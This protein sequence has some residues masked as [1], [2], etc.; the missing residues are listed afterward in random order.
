[1][2]FLLLGLTT[3]IILIY[4][5]FIKN[6]KISFSILIISFLSIS[7]VFMLDKSLKARYLSIFTSGSGIAKVTY[8]DS[9]KPVNLIENFSDLKDVDLSFRDSM[10]GAHFI[11]AYQ[12]FRENIILGSGAR[13]FRYECNKE[14]YDNIDIHY[15]KKRCSTHPHNYYLEILSEN[16]IIGF[17]YLLLLLSLFYY[18]EIKFF[19]KNKNL[20]HLFGILSI[21]INLWP[22][23]STGIY[24]HLLMV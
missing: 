12:I 19:L 14:K 23:A 13:S 21:F 18:Y 22:I 3:F 17:A 5:F 11:T 20:L 24:M 10:W 9:N 16:G 15:I 7:T 4:S 2:A 1:M 8:D 6:F